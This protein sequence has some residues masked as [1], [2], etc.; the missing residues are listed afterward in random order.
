M[1]SEALK[2]RPFCGGNAEY[3]KGM[4]VF[5]DYQVMCRV[6]YVCTANFD[7]GDGAQNKL[8]AAKAWN[9]RHQ[10][11]PIRNLIEAARHWVQYDKNEHADFVQLRQARE[12]LEKM[13]NPHWTLWRGNN[14]T[15]SIK[16]WYN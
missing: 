2:Q 4:M 15:K 12:D 13:W 7:D 1:T 9:T 3:Q 6:C 5:E 11:T 16:L 14:V 10:S 8:E